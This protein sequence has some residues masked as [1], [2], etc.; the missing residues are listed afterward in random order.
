VTHPALSEAVGSNKADSILET[1][2]DVVV[3]GC[4]SCLTQLKAMLAAKG[5]KIKV[6]HPVELL[7]ESYKIDTEEER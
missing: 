1:K 7:A 5:S 3:S 6:M 4:P 2:A